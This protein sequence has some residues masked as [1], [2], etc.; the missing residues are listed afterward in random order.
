MAASVAARSVNCSTGSKAF[1]LARST[2]GSSCKYE[3]G[4]PGSFGH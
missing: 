2:A 1:W 3:R 4:C